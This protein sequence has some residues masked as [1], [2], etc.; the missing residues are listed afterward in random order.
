[1]FYIFN[2]FLQGNKEND[3]FFTKFF[4]NKVHF[5]K[6]KKHDFDSEYCNNG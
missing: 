4:N 3:D 2:E 1:M 5:S 6:K